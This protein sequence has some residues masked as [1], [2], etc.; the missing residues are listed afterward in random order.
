MKYVMIG[1][2][3]MKTH[4]TMQPT[5]RKTMAENINQ[6][7]GAFFTNGDIEVNREKR[8]CCLTSCNKLH[9]LLF[10]CYNILASGSFSQTFLIKLTRGVH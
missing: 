8:S 10:V 3:Y 4:K 2:S 9:L 5:S 7:N 1:L 6:L